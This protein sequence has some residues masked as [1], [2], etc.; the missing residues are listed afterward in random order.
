[1]RLVERI[2]RGLTSIEDARIVEGLIWALL[3][4]LGRAWDCP[5]RQAAMRALARAID[6]DR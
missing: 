5:E 6:P 2:E 4:L 1:M 3:V